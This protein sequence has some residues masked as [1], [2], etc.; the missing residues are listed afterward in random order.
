MLICGENEVK[1][2]KLTLKNQETGEQV[3]VAREEI[4]QIVKL[5]KR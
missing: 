4:A 5:T 2:G 1:A 3:S